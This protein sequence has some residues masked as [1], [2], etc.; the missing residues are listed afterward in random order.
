M[1]A[2][3]G[4]F[5]LRQKP[6]DKALSWDG[7]QGLVG[8]KLRLARARTQIFSDYNQPAPPSW[9][10]PSSCLALSRTSLSNFHDFQVRGSCAGALSGGL[11]PLPPLPSGGSCAIG[12]RTQRELVITTEGH[13][14]GQR[15][16]KPL[17]PAHQASGAELFVLQD[18]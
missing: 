17:L 2:V 1:G 12:R 8:K 13:L 10:S 3:G 11:A 14:P 9:T 16:C 7:L 4:E 18:S 6:A 15:L 5:Q